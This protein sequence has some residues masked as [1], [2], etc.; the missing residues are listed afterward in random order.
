[1][2]SISKSEILLDKPMTCKRLGQVLL[3]GRGKPAEAVEKPKNALE[4]HIITQSLPPQSIDLNALYQAY[5]QLERTEDRRQS[6]EQLLPI[7]AALDARG[8]QAW[9]GQTLAVVY[10]ELKNVEPIEENLQK[11][12][13]LHQRTGD[14]GDAAHD[15][16]LL[17]LLYGDTDRFGEAKTKF[18]RAL[19]LAEELGSV[20][21]QLT[22]LEHFAG[23]YTLQGKTSQAEEFHRRALELSGDPVSSVTDDKNTRSRSEGVT[24]YLQISGAEVVITD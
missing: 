17:G 9:A 15:S 22:I 24:D 16:V 23:L 3:L 10:Q 11:A 19:E 5:T 12:L 20:Q 14:K 2:D 21:G 18:L 8:L 4:L 7:Y 6:L 13:E 1:M